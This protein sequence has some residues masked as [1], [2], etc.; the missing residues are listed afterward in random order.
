ML[1]NEFPWLPLALLGVMSELEWDDYMAPYPCQVD[2]GKSG[3][4]S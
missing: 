2:L 3:L 4:A 1:W